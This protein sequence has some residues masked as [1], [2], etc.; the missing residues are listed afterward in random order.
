[1]IETHQLTLEGFTHSNPTAS[2]LQRAVA[3]PSAI[4]DA[5]SIL[6]GSWTRVETYCSTLFG[7]RS[8][9]HTWTLITGTAARPY[10]Y[11]TIADGTDLTLEIWRDDAW[12]E[13]NARYG[14]DGYL[15][16][17]ETGETYRTR[18]MLYGEQ[19]TPAAVIR[20]VLRLSAWEASA[21]G[22]AYR[23][24]RGGTT[25]TMGVFTQGMRRSGAAALLRPYT[26]SSQ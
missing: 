5:D 10:P 19:S 12:E 8:I 20:A 11:S 15:R 13:V 21:T 1:M 24:D 2:R 22:S 25:P 23:H 18:S 16:D 9:S 7:Q 4:P 26:W 17:L 14:P 6:D 3:S